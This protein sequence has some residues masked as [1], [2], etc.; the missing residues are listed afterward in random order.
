ML[1]DLK[2]IIEV[3]GASK[4]FEALLET[5]RLLTSGIVSMRRAP[6]ARGRVFNTAGLLRLE[7]ELKAEMVCVCD[8]CGVTFEREKCLNIS[9]PLSVSEEDDGE[10]FPL[11]GDA[12]ELD[13]A[14]E[15]VFLLDAETKCLCRPDCRGLCPVCGKN[16]NEGPCG[17]GKRSVDPRFAVLEQ[18]LDNSPDA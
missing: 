12:L 13:D 11:T 5:D 6:V 15:T 4:P 2:D 14:L 1:L 9:L 8:R 18:L 7:G 3:P 16:L 10:A 17:C